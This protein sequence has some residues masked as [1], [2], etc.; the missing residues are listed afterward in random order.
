MPFSPH[1]HHLPSNYFSFST[2]TYPESF[3]SQL[4]YWA[5]SPPPI[6]SW[7]YSSYA[8]S[9]CFWQV[10]TLLFFVLFCFICLLGVYLALAWDKEVSLNVCLSWLAWHTVG[11]RCR[12]A[13]FLLHPPT[14]PAPIMP[15]SLCLHPPRLHL[16]GVWSNSTQEPQ[17]QIK[18]NSMSPRPDQ[19]R[20]GGSSG[21]EEVTPYMHKSP[22]TAQTENISVKEMLSFYWDESWLR[23]IL[24]VSLSNQCVMTLIGT[25]VKELQ[26]Q[27][28]KS[29]DRHVGRKRALD[30]LC[31]TIIKAISSL[32]KHLMQRDS[33]LA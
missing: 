15:Q 4:F 29:T 2:T 22:H 5:A 27:V 24:R 32:T 14:C 26:C 21:R 12:P 7:L 18:H 28:F 1:I 31:A 23:N 16:S 13:L 19:T 11:L 30:S 33:F 6:P 9:R 20:P 3:I 17:R 25:V 8:C 10:I